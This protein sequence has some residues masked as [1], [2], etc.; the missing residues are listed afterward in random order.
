MQPPFVQRAAA[1]DSLPEHDELVWDD[2]VAPETCLDFDA[3]HVSG[4]ET[5]AALL[6]GFAFF[7][8]LYT[9]QK[10]KDPEAMRPTADREMPY[11]GLHLALGGDPNKMPGAEESGEEE[12]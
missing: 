1:Y 6:G 11:N 8:M 10:M 12:E 4:G 7:G 2:G 9:Y 3:A 5:W